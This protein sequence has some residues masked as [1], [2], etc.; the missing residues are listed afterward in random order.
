MVYNTVLLSLGMKFSE[1]FLTQPFLRLESMKRIISMTRQAY[2]IQSADCDCLWC[3]IKVATLSDCNKLIKMRGPQNRSS[4]WT[5][6]T[7]IHLIRFW[8]MLDIKLR[9]IPSKGMLYSYESYVYLLLYFVVPLQSKTI[10][11]DQRFV[12][13]WNLKNVLNQIALLT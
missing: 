12:F 13:L 10:D 4:C 8:A 3:Y 5:E 9:K 11:R 6:A 7:A 1:E 2:F